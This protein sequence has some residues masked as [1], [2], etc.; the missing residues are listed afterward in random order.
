MRATC[1][2]AAIDQVTVVLPRRVMNSRRLIVAP[3]AW[4][5]DRTNSY[6]RSGRGAV[7][8]WVIPLL[9]KSRPVRGQKAGDAVGAAGLCRGVK[10]ECEMPVPGM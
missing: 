4:T 8:D 2:Q 6:M 7:R 9:V 5:G 10:V 1:A 3:E